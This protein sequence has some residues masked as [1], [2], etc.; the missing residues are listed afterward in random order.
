MNDKKQYPPATKPANVDA[1]DAST[2]FPVPEGE[3]PAV[4]KKRKKKKPKKRNAFGIDHKTKRP[5]NS[6][7]SHFLRR[8]TAKAADTTKRT[9]KQQ[10]SHSATKTLGGT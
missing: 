4:G 5:T 7:D 3:T 9:A 1:A 10:S 6:V 8:T 2:I